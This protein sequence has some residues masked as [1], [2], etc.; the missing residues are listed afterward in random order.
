M[1][2]ENKTVQE[3]EK[4]GAS[5]EGVV[6]T[7]TKAQAEKALKKFGHSDKFITDHPDPQKRGA[8]DSKEETFLAGEH[9]KTLQDQGGLEGKVAR[10]ATKYLRVEGSETTILL[11][12]AEHTELGKRGVKLTKAT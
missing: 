7:I 3:M 2:G 10:I 1:A 11:S 5:G 9:A 6:Y 8:A 4:L 12:K